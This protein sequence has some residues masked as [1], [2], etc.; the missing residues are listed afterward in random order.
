MI[1]GAVI[2]AMIETVVDSRA[3]GEQPLGALRG[4]PRGLRSS[5]AGGLHEVAEPWVIPVHF[6]QR[7]PAQDPAFPLAPHGGFTDSGEAHPHR[8]RRRRLASE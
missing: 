6:G 5:V 3:I 7:G 2:M 4:S 1:S 8:P